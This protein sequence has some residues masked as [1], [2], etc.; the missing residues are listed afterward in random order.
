MSLRAALLPDEDVPSNRICPIGD[1]RSPPIELKA[2]N[3][4]RCLM[5][6]YIWSLQGK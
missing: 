3:S 2:S 4:L 5:E 6:L 1:G